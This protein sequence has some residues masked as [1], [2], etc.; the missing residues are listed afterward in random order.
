MSETTTQPPASEKITVTARVA[1]MVREAVEKSTLQLPQ[2]YSADNAL[3][4]AWLTLQETKD[5]NDMPVLQVCTE[6][7]IMNALMQMVIEGL[8]TAKDQGYFMAYGNVLAWQRSYFGDQALAKRLVPGIDIYS[9]VVYLG[10]EFEFEI[11]R[12]RKVVSK[13]K[14]SLENQDP[15]KIK[16]AYCGAYKE[17]T[18]EDLGAIIMTYADIKQSWSMSKTYKENGAGPHNKFPDRFCQRTVTRR[19]C[20]PIINTSSDAELLRAIRQY[21][22]FV[23]EAEAS[24]VASINANAQPIDIATPPVVIVAPAITAAS[25]SAVPM[26]TFTAEPEKVPVET[27]PATNGQMSLQTEE[28]PGY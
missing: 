28:G 2:D 14:S 9:A 27:T 10:D 12:G 24:S 13:H 17:D 4:A 6:I 15:S 19:R 16:A 7:S 18:G 5:K 22:A 21:E 11:I 8:T 26:P 25:E 20:L 1:K 23:A 3:K